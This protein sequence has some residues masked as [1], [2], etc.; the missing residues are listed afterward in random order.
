MPFIWN[1]NVFSCRNIHVG[2]PFNPDTWMGPVCSQQHF[3]RIRMYLQIAKQEGA[4]FLTGDD[5]EQNQ[6]QLPEEN[7][8]VSIK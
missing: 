7:K 4:I 8:A 3:D 2:D 6:L 5:E 1:F